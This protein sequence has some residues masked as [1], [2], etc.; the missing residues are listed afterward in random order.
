MN[1]QTKSQRTGVWRRWLT[2]PFSRDTRCVLIAI[3][4]IALLAAVA[5]R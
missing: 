2:S 1:E 5:L 3:V 4:I